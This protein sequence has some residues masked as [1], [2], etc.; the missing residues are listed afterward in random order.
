MF[1]FS[2]KM[3]I[4]KFLE[5]RNLDNK[6]VPIT[7][8]INNDKPL[9]PASSTPVNNI[10]AATSTEKEKQE[11]VK[12]INLTVLNG[13]GRAGVASKAAQIIF[14]AG[15]ATSTIGNAENFNYSTTT[16]KYKKLFLDK[17][18]QIN[19]LFTIEIEMR[20]AADQVEDIIVIMG[21]NY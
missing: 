20:E 7:A 5:Q 9:T 18:S 16:I 4:N 10:E 21:K 2:F 3:I 6:S 13:S 1:L 17:A 15:I 12:K 19:K 14:Q 8:Q 11:A